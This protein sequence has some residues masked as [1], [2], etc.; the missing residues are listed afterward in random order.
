MKK[1]L[2]LL[3]ALTLLTSCGGKV[4]KS[5]SIDK[6]ETLN[7]VSQSAVIEELAKEVNFE[8][9]AEVI[10]TKTIEAGAFEID[11]PASW[12]YITP[13]YF[14]ERS[15]DASTA[16]WLHTDVDYSLSVSSVETSEDYSKEILHSFTEKTVTDASLEEFRFENINGIDAVYALYSC[17]F[18][19]LNS[20]SKLYLLRNPNGNGFTIFQF[21][22]SDNSRFNHFEEFDTVL[23][24]IRPKGNLSSDAVLSATSEPSS[25]PTPIPT[26][27]P[28]PLPTP[29]PTPSP[30]PTPTPEPSL[31]VAQER[32]TPA[33]DCGWIS[34]PSFPDG[35]YCSYHPEWYGITA[36]VSQPETYVEPSYQEPSGNYSN[37][38]TW[39][40]PYAGA[41]PYI[42]NANPSSHKFHYSW[43]G[44]VSDMNPSNRVEFYSRDEAINYGYTPCK[45]C[46]P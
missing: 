21:L 26:P 20:K 9:S 32:S 46:N 28:T 12:K 38:Q 22:Q 11:I 18:K 24:T 23:N 13:Y 39:D 37:F 43:C 29:E 14:V 45:R 7:N 4:E 36:A 16:T 17:T 42:G 41:A 31:P 30:T 27:I 5:D 6:E 25:E 2:G 15:P 3:F 35:G 8:E 34:D 33:D 44:S 1:I 19:N 40:D 10:Q